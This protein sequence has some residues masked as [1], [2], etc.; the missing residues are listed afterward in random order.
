MVSKKEFIMYCVYFKYT[1]IESFQNI[2]KLKLATYIFYL[3]CAVYYIIFKKKIYFLKI[4]IKKVCE[5]LF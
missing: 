1:S 4:K 3:S 2:F 5:K